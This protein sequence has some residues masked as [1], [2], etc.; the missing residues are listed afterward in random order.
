MGSS[1]LFIIPIPFDQT[2]YFAFEALLRPN[3][4]TKQFLFY[5]SKY[6]V[7]KAVHDFIAKVSLIGVTQCYLC[8][9]IVC[10]PLNLLFNLYSLSLSMVSSP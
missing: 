2:S 5:A 10:C 9:S 7:V 4:D 1:F 8:L 3:K 6:H